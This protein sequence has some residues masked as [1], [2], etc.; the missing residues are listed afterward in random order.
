MFES[1]AKLSILYGDRAESSA[2]FHVDKIHEF[3][4]VDKWFSSGTVI[5][6]VIVGYGMCT[7]L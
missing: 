6:M 4:V 5:V 7:F 2:H 3:I 1:I